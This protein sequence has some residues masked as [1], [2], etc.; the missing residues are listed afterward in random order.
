MS[1]IVSSR[2]P[3]Q[4]VRDTVTSLPAEARGRAYLV[5]AELFSRR[6][7][8]DDALRAFYPD[9]KDRIR[10][11]S[12]RAL[13]NTRAL[14]DVIMQAAGVLVP[15]LE[16]GAVRPPPP[17]P[18]EDSAEHGRAVVEH[19]HTQQAVLYFLR[20]E[21][22]AERWAT[23]RGVVQSAAFTLAELRPL[24]V[25]DGPLFWNIPLNDLEKEALLRDLIEDNPEE[26]L[27]LA[28]DTTGE[29]KTLFAR[30]GMRV[31]VAANEPLDKL[32]RWVD[33]SPDVLQQMMEALCVRNKTELLAAF[34][35]RFPE[36]MAFIC[37]T[38]YSHHHGATA[39]ALLSRVY[40][41]PGGEKAALASCLRG[42]AA[43]GRASDIHA[44]LKRFL[45]TR[46]TGDELTLACKA[47]AYEAGRS[48]NDSIVQLIDKKIAGLPKKDAK[49]LAKVIAIHA[50]VGTT[51]AENASAR[52]LAE[53]IIE[54]NRKVQLG[55]VILSDQP[56]EDLITDAVVSLASSDYAIE[57]LFGFWDWEAVRP[58]VREKQIRIACV[59]AIQFGRM[60]NLIALLDHP[61]VAVMEDREHFALV[62]EMACFAAQ[63]G[64]TAIVN[65]VLRHPWVS[66]HAVGARFGL[67][68]AIGYDA[69]ERGQIATMNAVLNHPWISTL[70]PV[71]RL[72]VMRGIAFGASRH[73]EAT[74]EALWAHPLFA[75]LNRAQRQDVRRDIVR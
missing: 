29:L 52:V 55:V 73:R 75:A 56:T 30:V 44:V 53:K 54:Q 60:A 38:L 57:R 62:K 17:L 36:H 39:L 8:L 18:M 25:G 63:C 7:T 16:L 14:A 12:P 40:L 48:G 43:R 61:A 24:F 72:D 69:A 4:S 23:V 2:D 21:M 41:P 1:V 5:A 66:E 46:P 26:A 71:G 9:L 51:E 50:W 67:L 28:G 42:V 34:L 68:R 64:H 45:A 32:L 58:G 59:N 11:L 22:A 20:K 35:D 49:S 65:A 37:A 10:A 15:G 19:M 70:D 6:I 3:Y 31:F 74:E 47:C 27:A 33:L 13:V